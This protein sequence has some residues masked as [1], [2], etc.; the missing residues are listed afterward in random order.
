MKEMKWGDG[1]QGTVRKVDI[2]LPLSFITAIFGLVSYEENFTEIGLICLCI[3]GL[4]FMS[5]FLVAV[6]TNTGRGKKCETK[7]NKSNG[8]K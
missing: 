6:D 1:T 8:K 4:S 2:I 7:A 5:I 3:A